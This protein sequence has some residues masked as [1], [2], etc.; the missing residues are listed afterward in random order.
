[1]FVDPLLSD[2]DMVI[3]DEVHERSLEIDIL[4]CLLKKIIIRQ[5]QQNDN[6]SKRLKL[7]C[8]SATINS[9]LFS[10]YYWDC[11]MGFFFVQFFF[12]VYI[13]WGFIMDS[14]C[15]REDL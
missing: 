5:A 3:I 2:V 1:M 13:F 6:G 14:S 12:D 11:P 7:V 15:S 4:L 10:S 9:Q 8:M